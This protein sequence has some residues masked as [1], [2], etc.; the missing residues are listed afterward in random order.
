MIPVADPAPAG[1]NAGR[2]KFARPNR[3]LRVT[4][5]RNWAEGKGGMALRVV[6]SFHR[7]VAAVP[8][9]IA[10]FLPIH[11]AAIVTVSIVAKNIS[12]VIE[13]NIQNDI[14]AKLVGALHQPLQVN[15]CAKMRIHLQ[16]I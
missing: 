9:R 15:R 5:F 6:E 1:E 2:L 13:D 10:D 7:I 4:A 14:D 11:Q 3:I 8:A 16:K 12:A